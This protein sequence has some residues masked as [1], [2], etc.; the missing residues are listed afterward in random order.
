MIWRGLSF[1]DTKGLSSLAPGKREEERPW[2]RGCLHATRCQSVNK[3]AFSNV[4]IFWAFA[5]FF[6]A[7]VLTEAL[8]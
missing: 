8:L 3:V 6:A 5:V 1:R 2:E 7:Y 4:A